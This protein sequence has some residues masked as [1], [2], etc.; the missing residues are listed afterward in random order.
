MSSKWDAVR[1]RYGRVH[2]L[3]KGKDVHHWF[4]EQGSAT[5]KW[6]KARGGDFI[7]NHPLNLNPLVTNSVN[8]GR[9]NRVHPAVA[10]VIGSPGWARA[11]TGYFSTGLIA[12]AYSEGENCAC[13]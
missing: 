6:L 8:R 5:G 12:D 9:L 11:S 13:K 2:E 7:V 3:P 4:I 1:K 10:T